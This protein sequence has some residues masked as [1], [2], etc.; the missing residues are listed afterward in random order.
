[1]FS[2]AFHVHSKSA[3]VIG[4]PS[5]QTASGLILIVS[6]MAAPAAGGGARCR[7]VASAGA[8]AGLGGRGLAAA[9]RVR[10]VSL[11]LPSSSLPQ[12]AATSAVPASSATSLA[13]LGVLL[14]YLTSWLGGSGGRST[15]NAC[16]L[17]RWSR[18][19]APSGGGAA[20]T[21]RL[22]P[23]FDRSTSTRLTS[24]STYRLMDAVEQLARV[25]T[26]R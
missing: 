22:G 25:V 18:A 14:T 3:T 23:A 24:P 17:G 2:V 12:A 15:P 8:G 9:G 6:V 20:G 1:M 16:A 11:L 19:A 21:A 7:V 13:L 4:V 26:D 10:S 5:S